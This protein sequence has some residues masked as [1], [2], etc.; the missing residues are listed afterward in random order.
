MHDAYQ[1]ALSIALEQTSP[2]RVLIPPGP[3]ATAAEFYALFTDQG[4]GARRLLARVLWDFYRGEQLRY[5]PRHAAESHAEFARRPHRHTLNLT[6]VLVDVLSQ[7]YRRPVKRAITGDH[8]AAERIRRV[9]ARNPLDLLLLNLDRLARLQGVAALGASWQDGEIRLW[10]WPAHRL[11]VVPDPHWPAAPLA[12][13]AFAAG[14]GGVAQVWTPDRHALVS[15]GRVAREADHGLG[16]V[17]FAFVHDRSPVDGF[18]VEGRGVSIVPANAEFNAKLTELAQT[19]SLQGFGVMEIVNPDPAQPLVLSPARAIQFRVSGDQPFGVNFKAPNAPIGDLIADL[20]F[21]LRAL[22]KS[23]RIPES[24]LSVHA[25][26]DASGVSILAQQTPVLEDRVE[27]QQLFRAVEADV[28]DLCL[29]LAREHEGTGGRAELRV[30][31]PEPELEQSAHER[32]AADEWRLRHGLV[33]P[34]QLMRR[35]DPDGFATDE[36][37]RAAWQANLQA[38]RQAGSPAADL[39]P[40]A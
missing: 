36:E 4:E 19:A 16:R 14:D 1:L 40:K 38:M 33:T 6:R 28:A 17:P 34:W 29:A 39:E 18:W 9:L 10:P 13:V 22:L 15:Q 12:V 30:N 24:V 8:R 37:A 7:L 3:G 27:R 20:E 11:C 32:L 5:L 26:S 35:D 21:C 2:P 25:S 23:Q 31:Y